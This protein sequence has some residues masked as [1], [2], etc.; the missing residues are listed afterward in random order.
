[1]ACGAAV[2]TDNPSGGT[3]KGGAGGLVPDAGV[4]V[5]GIGNE[6]TPV[7][8]GTDFDVCTG[9]AEEAENTRAPA[10]IVFLV[11]NS[12]SMRDEILWT[13]QN[14]NEF[15][16]SIAEQGI[17]PRIVMISCLLDGCD[18]HANTL[19]ICIDPPVG[20]GDCATSDTNA[21]DYLHV[22]LRMPSAKLLQR[23]ISSY[24]R[25]QSVLRPSALTH[26]VAISD[27]ADLTS[28][29]DFQS[30]LAAL[31]PQVSRF[32]F[33]GIF[34]SMSKEDACA[35]STSNPCCTYAAPGGEGVSY[36]DLANATGGVAA[37]LCAQDFAPV[38]A[39]FA[40]SVITHSE[41]N[42]EWVIPQPPA[43]QA[44]DP[45]LINVKFSSAG[46]STY[47]GY[48]ASPNDCSTLDN[49]WYYDNPTAPSRV[50]VCPNT[51]NRIRSAPA[52]SVAVS[53]GCKT[54]EVS[55]LL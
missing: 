39:Q 55:T 50:L 43:G 6:V 20:S 12:P 44:L 23:A 9:V 30:Q 46:N 35:V 32:V 36:R 31:N 25:W 42:C 18:G 51:C 14:M 37:D 7:A 21:P 49:A 10:D 45:N 33:H 38:F 1:M 3:A 24:A 48:V 2:T 13:R 17:D 40:Q 11:D 47:F 27:D 15:S 19:G 28:A 52:P 26:F 53:F 29:A 34:S 5:G 54:V 4:S 16:R 8:P 22:D 41:L